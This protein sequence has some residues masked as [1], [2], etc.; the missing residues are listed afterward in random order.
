MAELKQKKDEL[1]VDLENKYAQGQER[2]LKLVADAELSLAFLSGNQWVK[3]SIS[4]G[5]SQIENP[6]NEVRVTDNRMLNAYRRWLFYMFKTDPVITAFEGGYELHDAE[7]AAVSAKLCDYWEK[8]NGWRASRRDIMGWVASCGIGYQTVDWRRRKGRKVRRKRVKFMDQ[9]VTDKA[10]RVSFLQDVEVE[11]WEGDLEF[12]SLHPLTTY[13]FPL[14]AKKWD[15]VTGILSADVVTGDWIKENLD[16]TVDV[17]ELEH[18]KEEMLNRRVLER[19]NDYIGPEFGYAPS[20]RD[21]NER[22]YLVVHWRQRPCSD[23]PKGRYVVTAGGRIFVDRDLPYLSAARQ[24]DPGDV[25][26]LTMGVIPYRAFVL[27]GRLY[28]PSLMS[29]LRDAQI[30]WNDLLTDEAR[31]R[32]T[33]G[34]SKLLYEEGTLDDDEW[35]NEHG[36]KIPLRKHASIAPQYIQGQPLSGIQAEKMTALSAFEEASGQTEVLRGQNP[37]QVRAAF[38]LDI[39]REESMALPYS[40]IE[41]MEEAYELTA[42]LALAIAKEKYQPERVVQIYGRD[43]AGQALTFHTAVINT[44]VRVKRGSM[45]PRNH[46]VYE[47]KLSEL[48]AVGAFTDPVTGKMNTDL[49][50]QMSS[51]GTLNQAVDHKAKHRNRA[52]AENVLILVYKQVVAPMEHEDHYLHIEEHRGAM[53]RPE[54]Y[55]APNEVQAAILEHLEMHSAMLGNQL[56]PKLGA[57]P[58]VSA[59]G[60]VPGG[61]GGSGSLPALQ[62]PAGGGATGA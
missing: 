47:A 59:A 45:R 42:R 41:A 51:L 13:C 19:I 24:I 9:P 40:D 12:G 36:E 3:I 31:N 21:A 61:G 23:Y 8:T 14:N 43:R 5:I 10:G 32:K 17:D 54:F 28:P 57:P 34:R 15:D 18:V 22:M 11:D 7:V 55:Q 16:K 2:H 37:A 46:A 39:L 30:R 25:H 44:D 26:N 29:Q 62:A 38:H 1:A 35:T 52:R 33:V 49:Y 6:V 53:A 4:K 56:A 50:W 60:A 48:L 58:M 20:D 27:P